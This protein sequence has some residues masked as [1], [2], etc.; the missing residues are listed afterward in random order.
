MHNHVCFGLSP[1]QKRIHR[2]SVNSSLVCVDLLSGNTLYEKKL[3]TKGLL[4]HLVGANVLDIWDYTLMPVKD[5]T[6]EI[7]KYKMLGPIDI[8]DTR[9]FIIKHWNKIWGP[10]EFQE[11]F[12]NYAN[13][14]LFKNVVHS[15]LLFSFYKNYKHLALSSQINS[16]TSIEMPTSWDLLKPIIVPMLDSLFARLRIDNWEEKILRLQ[17][18][19]I[20][21]GAEVKPHVDIGFYSNNAHRIHIPI[22]SSKCIVFSQK[23]NNQWQEVPFKEGEAFEINNKIKHRVQQHGPYN[24]VTMIIDYMD[25]KCSSFAQLEQNLIDGDVKQNLDILEWRGEL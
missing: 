21:K 6:K 23:V 4:N 2:L 10:F 18:N 5:K 13:P 15:R 19:L 16:D 20:P 22:F 8:Y 14:R 12:S 9:N 17:F 1:P 3:I 24:R 7:T 11:V 25:R